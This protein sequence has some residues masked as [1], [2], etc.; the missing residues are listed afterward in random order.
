[1][2]REWATKLETKSNPCNLNPWRGALTKSHCIV[3]KM[4]QRLCRIERGGGD[5][6]FERESRFWQSY[7]LFLC[8]YKDRITPRKLHFSDT[9]HHKSII[10][11]R[12]Q[13]GSKIPASW[14]CRF[15]YNNKVAILKNGGP[16][17]GTE[18]KRRQQ[19]KCA[20][21]FV[22]FHKNTAHCS[23]HTYVICPT[24]RRISSA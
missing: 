23:L 7:I 13:S 9:N 17:W 10:W 24:L 16:N 21:L 22:E 2:F 1:M 14:H 19:K 5:S 20:L 6:I 18:N 15:L 12:W 11:I 4:M 8:K 3:Q